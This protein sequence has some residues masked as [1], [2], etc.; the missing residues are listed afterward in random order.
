MNYAK[1]YKALMTRAENRVLDVYTE[2]HHVVP[3]CIDRTSAVV[4]RLTPEEHYVAHQLLVKMYPSN[5]KLLF[6]ARQMTFATKRS[7]RR[8]KLFGWLRRRAAESLKG[9]QRGTGYRHT[10]EAKQRIS[11][12]GYLHPKASDTPEVASQKLVLI[13]LNAETKELERRL[14]LLASREKQND[15]L[16]AAALAMKGRT[17]S[18]THHANCAAAQQ[19][20]KGK[21]NKPHRL[22]AE[23]KEARAAANKS[24]VWTEEMRK[25]AAASARVREANKRNVLVQADGV[26]SEV[27]LA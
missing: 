4:V 17:M 27:A 12:A 20:R 24:R 26:R 13:A 3:R 16:R 6:A 14:R 25:K 18:E 2:K 5:Q 11:E 8:N 22:S 10:E 7:P 1:H 23:G 9:N 15:A 19:R 21:P